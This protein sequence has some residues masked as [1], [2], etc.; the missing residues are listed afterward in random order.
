MFKIDD[1]KEV[2][3]LAATA[4]T[5]INELMKIK[6]NSKKANK[7]NA[8]LASSGNYAQLASSG[9]YAQLAS[10][11]YSAQLA[12][13]GN[14]A[15]LASSGYSAK[16]ASSGN[17]AKLA[18]SGD[19]AVIAAVGYWAVA[20]AKKGSWITL[21][22]YRINKD[23]KYYP[24]FVKSEYVDGAKIKENTLYGIYNK[25]FREIIEV[26]GIQSLL[27]SKKNNL[28]KVVL[29]EDF[30][31]SYI[32]TKDG[33]SAH[34]RTVK[35]AYRDWLYKTSPRDMSEYE[36]LKL[37]DIRDLNFWAVCYR[38]ITGAC[39]LGT[40][41]FIETFKD[42]IKPQMTLQEVINLTIGQYGHNTFINF[43]ENTK[44]KKEK[45]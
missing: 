21:C 34:G 41:N 11:G 26:D 14:Y 1:L 36:C 20:S 13:S 2:F 4:G 18:S 19:S 27:I 39:A 15:K 42:K 16:L 6:R 33:V 45:Q 25:E 32:F 9:D 5:F 28:Q 35:Q 29:N 12:S 17:Y 40:E 31:P 43:F 38:T 23:K 8:K 10:S 22:E 37:N 24:Y 3:E 44:D 30:V 7:D